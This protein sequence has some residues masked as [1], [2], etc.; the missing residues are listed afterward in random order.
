MPPKWCPKKIC[1]GSILN[2]ELGHAWGIIGC[3]H[4]Y[5]IMY[6]PSAG[7]HSEDNIFFEA[8][9][10]PFQ[11]FYGFRFCKDCKKYLKKQGAFK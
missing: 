5:C 10:K 9:A 2:H 6:E 7:G 4:I 1:E 3:P 8:L 11:L